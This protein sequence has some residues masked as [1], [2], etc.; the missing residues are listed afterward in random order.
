MIGLF[1][2]LFFISVAKTVFLLL[3]AFWNNLIKFEACIQYVEQLTYFCFTLLMLHPPV[4]C[5]P[6]LAYHSYSI[7]SFCVRKSHD[8]IEWITSHLSSF[9]ALR[10]SSIF[11]DPRSEFYVA[12]GQ[13]ARL[14]HSCDVT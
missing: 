13:K 3:L 11:I 6:W 12:F 8:H 4:L 5:K 9:Y 7:F 1:F 10:V 14:Y 2:G